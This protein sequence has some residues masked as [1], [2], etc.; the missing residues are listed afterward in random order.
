MVLRPNGRG[1]VSLQSSDPEVPIL[2]D[3]KIL[4]NE[5]DVNVMM[6]GNSL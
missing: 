6:E 4:E 2:M 1:S 5:V 3:P